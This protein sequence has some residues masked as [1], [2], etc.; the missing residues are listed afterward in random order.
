MIAAIPPI[1]APGMPGQKIGPCGENRKK[2]TEVAQ[3]RNV[4][5]TRAAGAAK[6]K[7]TAGVRCGRATAKMQLARK[8]IP[9]KSVKPTTAADQ[10]DMTIHTTA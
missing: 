8:A 1:T 10:S 7:T 2:P 4:Q 3:A 5:T 6:H 9:T